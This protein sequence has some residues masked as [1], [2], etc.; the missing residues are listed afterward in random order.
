MLRDFIL[1]VTISAHREIKR[2][3]TLCG[4]C[5]TRR[6]SLA[7]KW[8]SLKKAH[9]VRCRSHDPLTNNQSQASSSQ[10]TIPPSSRAPSP[11]PSSSSTASTSLGGYI[12]GPNK[13]TGGST[14]I[15]SGSGRA[16]AAGNVF[17]ACLIC[18]R[19]VI[20]FTHSLLLSVE[21]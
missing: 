7:P 5:G 16:D 21:E 12:A 2:G 1:P 9:Q 14:G 15:G 19:Q 11:L 4:V 6:A 10:S 17:F 8:T 18:D 3:R 20:P 13:G